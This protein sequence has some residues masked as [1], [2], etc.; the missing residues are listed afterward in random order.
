MKSKA[1]STPVEA[2]ALCFPPLVEGT[3]IIPPTPDTVVPAIKRAAMGA[4]DSS[5]LRLRAENQ[6][7][8]SQLER[9]QLAQE[10]E[11]AKQK[12]RSKV[13]VLFTP[14]DCAGHFSTSSVFSRCS[15]A[16]RG[17]PPSWR[18]K[19]RLSWRK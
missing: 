12:V 6:K 14:R 5:S 10:E 16:R 15:Q 3:E 17:W 4:G 8:L 19:R 2:S 9:L 18:T 1:W 13:R 11:D 7:L